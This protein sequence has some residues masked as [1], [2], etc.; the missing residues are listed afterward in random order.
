V[1][2]ANDATGITIKNG[3]ERSFYLSGENQL[4][5]VG[6]GAGFVELWRSSHDADAA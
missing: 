6:K 2:T 1:L 4:A 5:V 3:E